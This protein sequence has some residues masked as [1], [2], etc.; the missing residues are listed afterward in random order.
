MVKKLNWVGSKKH[1]V[2]EIS[3][4]T[5]GEKVVLGRFGGNST[6]GQY[7]NEDGCLIWCD[8]KQD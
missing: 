6:A 8:D 5:V 7:K 1:F 2:D 4:M 3:V